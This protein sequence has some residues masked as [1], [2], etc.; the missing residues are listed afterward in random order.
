M[1]LLNKPVDPLAVIAR[2]R[3]AASRQQED[4]VG[5]SSKLE[6]SMSVSNEN[7]LVSVSC[8]QT[9]CLL[10]NGKIILQSMPKDLMPFTLNHALK[11]I[12]E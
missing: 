5:T 3:S 4:F 7:E 2:N 6:E 12:V 8:D 9:L 10:R 11:L 1:L